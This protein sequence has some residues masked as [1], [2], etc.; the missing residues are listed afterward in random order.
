MSRPGSRYPSAFGHTPSYRSYAK[1]TLDSPTIGYNVNLPGT[2]STGSYGTYSSGISRPGATS[3]GTLSLDSPPSLTAYSS[4]GPRDLAT[5]SNY[6]GSNN[7]SK[8]SKVIY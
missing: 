4:Y 8:V 6:S 5:S 1:G 2:G 3:L 7:I